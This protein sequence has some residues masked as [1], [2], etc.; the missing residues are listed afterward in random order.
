MNREKNI[1]NSITDL[2]RYLN[3]RLQRPLPGL[4][5]QLKMSVRPVSAF[6]NDQ[7]KS[8]PAWPAA[9]LVLFYPHQEDIYLVLIKRSGQVRHHQHQISFPGG[10][11]EENESLEQA[12]IREAEEEINVDPARVKLVGRLTPLYIEISKYCLY[13][14]VAITDLRPDFRPNP[15]EVTEI[16]ELPLAHLLDSKNRKEEWQWLRGQTVLVPFFEFNGYRIWGA[17]A[18]VLAELI[19]LLNEKEK[20]AGLA[21]HRNLS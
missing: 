17:T 12:A 18:M 5:S 1:F 13:P 15:Q 4:S 21:D 8:R 14:M 9:V 20:P 11:Q 2:E 7:R 16:I 6:I 19:D 10:Q 3:D